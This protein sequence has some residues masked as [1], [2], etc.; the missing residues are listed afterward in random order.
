MFLTQDALQKIGFKSLGKNVLVSEHANIYGADR[1]SIGDNSRIDDF[2]IL[3][4]GK[5]GF[6]IGSH[7]H[8]ACFVSLIGQARIVLKDFSGISSRVAIYSSTDKYDGE[9][10]TGPTIPSEF[11]DVYHAEVIIGKHVVIGAGSVVL[12]GV[13]IGDGSAV[14]SLSLVNRTLQE[15]IIA[16]GCPAKAIKARSGKIFSEEYR[17]KKFTS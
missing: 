5:D 8:I 4:A 14:G 12:P 2:C 7:V 10:L 17:L 15:G 11:L 3:S 13:E 1:I 6:E 9:H 16:F